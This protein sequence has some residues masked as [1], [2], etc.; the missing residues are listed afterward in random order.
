[1]RQRSQERISKTDGIKS[2]V[3]RLQRVVCG[4]NELCETWSPTPARRDAVSA[5]QRKIRRSG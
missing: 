5:S 4:R 3:H 1:M 2:T